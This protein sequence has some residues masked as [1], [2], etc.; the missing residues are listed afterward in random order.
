[1]NRFFKNAIFYVLIFL[2]IVGV[3]SYFNNSGTTVEQISYSQFVEY[4]EK[5]EVKSLSMQP[6]RQVY[7]IQGEL[8]NAA[9]DKNQFVTYVM[10]DPVIISKINDSID[11]S[12]V[13]VLPAEETGGWASLLISIIP[14][15]IIL[16]LFFFLMNK[17]IK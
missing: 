13:D 6:V 8:L 12:K 11:Q 14:F 5:D 2:V 17:H 15:V 4:L 10:N 3:L 1:M 7:Q 16:F 9:E